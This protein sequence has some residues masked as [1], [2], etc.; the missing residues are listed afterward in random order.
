ML[1]RRE[2]VPLHLK[3]L[4]GFAL[5][6]AISAVQSGF[7]Y[8]T[9]LASIGSD[10]AVVRSERV[11]RLASQ[12]HTELLEMDAAYRGFLFSG[13]EVL[14]GPY[15]AD[16]QVYTADLASLQQLTDDNPPQ[17]AR[18]R[19]LEQRLAAW[20][21][22]V[23]E[24][25]IAF[26]RALDSRTAASAED[27]LASAQRG[28]ALNSVPEMYRIL[29]DAIAI[30][31]DHLSER[32]Q[33]NQGLND[34]LIRSLAGGTLLRLA[35]GAL[36]AILFARSL[37]HA[38]RQ[39]S[40]AA[41]DLKI[42]EQR[43]RQ[44]FE[45]NEAVK[46]L[47]DPE[48][49]TIVDANAAACT[50]YGYA[51][52]ELLGRRLADISTMAVGD[53]SKRI[54]EVAARRRLHF[55]AQQRLASGE[56]RDV[57]VYSSHLDEATGRTLL[58]SIIHD[59]T[60][61]TRATEALRHQALHDG[62]TNLPNRIL[63]RERMQEAILVA[64]REGTSLALLLLDLDR[65]K[66]INDT[67]GHQYGDRLLQQIG[68]RLRSVLRASDTVAR[69]GGDEFAVLLPGGEPGDAAALAEQLLQVLREPFMLGEHR[70]E[71]GASIGIVASQEHGQDAE[72]LLRRAD[73]AMYVAKSS[74]SGLA[75]YTADQDH[76][77]PDRL[78]LVGELREA[79]D[80]DQLV[81]H[82]QPK[83]DFS[84]GL[85]GVEALV[86]WQ[87]PRRGMVPP[88]KFI[89]LAEHTGLIKPLTRWVL[90]TALRQC[91]RWLDDGQNIQVA[92]NVSTQDLQDQCMPD[93][94]AGL[95]ATWGVPAALLRLEITEGAIMSE[96][97]RAMDVLGRL[98]QL[99]VGV[100]V[101]DFGT[102][103]SSL[104]YLKRLPVDEL[105]IDRSF[106]RNLATDDDDAAIVRST[107][108]LGHEL[109]L[110]V[111]AEGVEDETTW[112]LL[113]RF[114]CDLVQG[115]FIGRPVVAAEL[116]RWLR[117][118]VPFRKPRLASAA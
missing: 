105:K 28:I 17:V 71:V 10:A 99:G 30:E 98:R 91:R 101:D 116:D 11:L 23:V 2:A 60:D 18:W 49:G 43:Y 7:A 88:D 47:V 39:V 5:V 16:F 6:L 59:I 78:A 74:R 115:Y 84:G 56:V 48:A 13:D 4:G 33:A 20:Q 96:P 41:A 114:G 113:E 109:G 1:R 46:L 50:F 82:Y 75:V 108:G 19:D 72:S 102:G 45:N 79:I 26:R 24:P 110:Q 86:R 9:T 65:F 37:A 66:E 76:H 85:A 14:L 27:V 12:A 94:L 67:F 35:I 3:L 52:E 32:L 104:A 36:V 89:E 81:L 70:F 15:A 95:L 107:I 100:S 111:I 97:A 25:G 92:V 40:A 90:D 118:P 44:M 87:H 117:E 77:S 68:P 93:A 51:R 73:V 69:L 22:E 38:L 112:R 63:L 31:Q 42:S 62:L 54:G 21:H 106:V 80:H 34:Q 58:Y 29:D 61:R 103:Y 8:W 53:L 57:E 64:E 83:V 55:E